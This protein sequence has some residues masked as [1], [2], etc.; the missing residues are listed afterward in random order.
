MGRGTKG[1]YGNMR[2]CSARLCMCGAPIGATLRLGVV[3]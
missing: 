1:A 3:L 2:D